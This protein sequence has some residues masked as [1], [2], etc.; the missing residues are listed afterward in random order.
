MSRDQE[1]LAKNEDM[2]RYEAETGK[3]AI[4]RGVITE[5]FKKWKRGE[6]IYNREKERIALYISE[7]DKN[8][9]TNFINSQDNLNL[10]KLIRNAVTFYIQNHDESKTFEQLTKISHDL[11]SPLTIIKGYADLLLNT[12]NKLDPSVVEKIREI[13]EKSKLMETM[14]KDI[15][16]KSPGHAKY[17]VLIVDDDPP[18]LDLLLGYFNFKQISCKG[19]PQGAGLVKELLESRPRVLLLDIILP[20]V[21]GFNLCKQIKSDPALK[22]TKVIFVTALPENHVQKRIADCR[23]DGYILKPFNLSSLDIVR[24]YI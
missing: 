19:L 21:D 13:F 14:I 1:E 5:N 9:W 24:K 2:V 23:A 10:S 7:E 8:R 11:K 17:D 22:E 20:E 16:D 12:G 6:K 4:W 15:I 3:V 18:T